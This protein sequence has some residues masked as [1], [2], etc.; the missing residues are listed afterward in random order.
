MVMSIR[1]FPTAEQV[2]GL[3]RAVVLELVAECLM[4]L[5]TGFGAAWPSPQNAA[6]RMT[7]ARSTMPSISQVTASP[8]FMRSSR[9]TIWYVPVPAGYALAAGLVA[10]EARQAQRDLD[11]ADPSP[12]T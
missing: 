8:R 4:Q 11:H 3:A 1:P 6:W 2:A 12:T 7:E 9:R 5:S 10:E